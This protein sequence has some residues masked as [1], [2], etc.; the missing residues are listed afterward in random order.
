MSDILKKRGHTSIDGLKIVAFVGVLED[1][2]T[3]E[4]LDCKHKGKTHAEYELEGCE[5][6]QV[7]CPE[8]GSIHYYLE[9]K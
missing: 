6:A 9:G 2:E 1:P 8:C 7:V 5:E 3:N 4:C